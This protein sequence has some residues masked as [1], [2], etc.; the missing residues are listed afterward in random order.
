MSLLINGLEVLEKKNGLVVKC[1]TNGKW[2]TNANVFASGCEMLDKATKRMMR[3][4]GSASNP[5]W[6]AEII[7]PVSEK[8]PK[9]KKAAKKSK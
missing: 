8:K 6:E 5:V 4:I 9:V 2:Y 1:E 3:N 7:E